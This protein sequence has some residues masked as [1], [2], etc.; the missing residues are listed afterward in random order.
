MTGSGL[1]SG[2]VRQVLCQ[3]FSDFLGH[4]VV[5]HKIIQHSLKIEPAI[6]LPGYC[7][8]LRHICLVVS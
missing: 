6:L 7:V 1:R 8:R 5:G 2:L 3:L 4:Q